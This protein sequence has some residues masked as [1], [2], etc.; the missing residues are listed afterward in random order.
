MIFSI[1]SRQTKR[2]VGTIE[3]IQLGQQ[4]RYGCGELKREG[5]VR[6]KHWPNVLQY[7]KSMEGYQL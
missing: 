7:K 3:L 5:R 6:K 4:W 2:V 1:C